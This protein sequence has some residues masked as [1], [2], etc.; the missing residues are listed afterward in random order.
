MRN[1]LKS[2]KNQSM[3]ELFEITGMK[4]I[5]NDSIVKRSANAKIAKSTLDNEIQNEIITSMNNLKEKNTLM[6]S[7][8]Q[9]VS[10]TVI[11]NWNSLINTLP[12]N[13]FNFCR[14]TL[15]FSLNNNS[16]LARWKIID[17]PNCDL[18]GKPQTQINFLNNCTSVI[19]DGH[20]KWRH[21]SIL[22]TIL[23]YLT[24]TNEYVFADVE[25]YKSSAVLFNINSRCSCY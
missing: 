9:K 20:F 7:L 21:D 2:S 8:Q 1:I 23:F 6:S 4:I 3:G 5:R 24:K 11:R 14:K 13:I 15:I 22:K 25:E 16:N 19:N 18:C 12:S 10:K 17:S